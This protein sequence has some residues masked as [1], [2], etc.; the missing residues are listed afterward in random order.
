MSR[1]EAPTKGRSVEAPPAARGSGYL[2]SSELMERVVSPPNLRA[3]LKRVKGNKGGP[4]MDGMTVEELVPHLRETWP[5]IRET[6]LAGTY[7]PS[8]V[9][10]QSIPK[11]GGGVRELGIPTVPAYCA[12]VQH[13]F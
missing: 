1:G 4:G 5:G 8:P 9:K 12:V 2:G 7:Q 3:A 11:S 6:L 10:R 13:R